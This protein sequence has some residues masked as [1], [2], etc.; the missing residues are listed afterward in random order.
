MATTEKLR[1]KRVTRVLVRIMGLLVKAII[2]LSC[3]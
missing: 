2:I 1:D 3:N